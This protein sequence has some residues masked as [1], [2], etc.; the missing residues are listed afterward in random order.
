[1]RGVWAQVTK[2]VGGLI[3]IEVFL[4]GGTLIILAIL[5]ARY[6]GPRLR[7]WMPRIGSRRAEASGWVVDPPAAG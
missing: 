4:P 7:A 5:L 3:W 2:Q 6:L 1:M